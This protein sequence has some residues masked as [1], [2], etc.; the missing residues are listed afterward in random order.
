MADKARNYASSPCMMHEVRPDVG[1]R[2]RLMPG[3]ALP[4]YAYLPGGRFLHPV[5]DPDGHSFGET[6][7]PVSD[8]SFASDAF[9]WGADLFN[10]GYYW[11]AHEAW[12]PLWRAARRG[13]PRRALL[14]GLILM[15]AAG[16]KAREG[17]PAACTKHA[18]RA[19]ALFRRVAAQ[20]PDLEGLDLGPACLGRHA[21]AVSR[22]PPS[23]LSGSPE[24]V[25]DFILRPTTG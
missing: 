6:A 14:K 20:A 9:R 12:E 3:R 21:E 25:F 11:E 18:G 8:P 23:R 1:A 22:Q 15:A 16:V 24:S 2:P 13:D 4:A 5:R 7:A 17:K 19:A 10:H